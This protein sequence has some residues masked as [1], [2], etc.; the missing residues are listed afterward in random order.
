MPVLARISKH[1]TEADPA[2]IAQDFVK[3]DAAPDADKRTLIVD[4]EAD[5]DKT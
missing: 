2:V 5:T 1:A 4:P 3:A